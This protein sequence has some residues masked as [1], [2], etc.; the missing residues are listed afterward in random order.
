MTFQTFPGSVQTLTLMS[1]ASWLDKTA[2]DAQLWSKSLLG[3]RH[4]QSPQSLIL[5][6]LHTE[7]YR[8]SLCRSET[9]SF[10]RS[11]RQHRA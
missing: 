6:I 7:H 11:A 2:C 4:R 5:Q 1:I 10:L 3:H 8:V 9:I